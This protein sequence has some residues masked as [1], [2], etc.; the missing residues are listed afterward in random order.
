MTRKITVSKA[1]F[2]DS[3]VILNDGTNQTAMFVKAGIV[4]LE[5]F[6][7][8]IDVT[9]WDENFLASFV[10][11]I[12]TGSGWAGTKLGTFNVPYVTT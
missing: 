4:T 8:T 12:F 5:E 1:T 2:D 9:H 10:N 7:S 11:P 6:L 3:S